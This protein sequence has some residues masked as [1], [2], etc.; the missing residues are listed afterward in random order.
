MWAAHDVEFLPG[1]LSRCMKVMKNAPASV[2][3]VYPR[4]EMIYDGQVRAYDRRNSIESKD[5][6]PY[7]RME[8]VARH[9]LMVTQLYSPVKADALKKTRLNG[10][11]ASSDYVLLAELAMLGEIWE[12]PETLIRRRIDSD[13]G[14]A[15]V[16]NDQ[17]S[18]RTWL[19]ANKSRSKSDWLPYRERLAFEYLRGAWHLPLKPKDRLF[20]L[21]VAPFLPYSRFVLRVTG[22]LRHKWRRLIGRADAV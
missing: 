19:A 18:W 4:C 11:Y 22:P 20:C 1:M 21:A 2:V 16:Y 9:I 8:N 14:T 17:K 12:L 15:A 10:L 7:R 3:L 5:P 6:R 13:R